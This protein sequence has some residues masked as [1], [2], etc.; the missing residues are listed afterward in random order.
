MF[1]ILLFAAILGSV[2]VVLLARYSP[3]LRLGRPLRGDAADRR[4][5]IPAAS[6]RALTVQLLHALGLSVVEGSEPDERSI[7]ATRREPLGE[8]RYIVALAPAPP[9][10]VVDQAAV[11]A[12]AEDVKGERAAVGM[13]ITPGE[14]ET[15]GLAGLDV[16]L[17]LLDGPRFRELIAQQ[18][19]QRLGE[20]DRYR[21]FGPSAAAPLEPL[22]PQST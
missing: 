20:L 12:L 1:A 16:T 9:G 10:G 17:E 19:P 15:A 22:V 11:V 5:P 8:I 4:P 18:L 2:L 7:V 13:L 3:P 14:I 6:L 21:G